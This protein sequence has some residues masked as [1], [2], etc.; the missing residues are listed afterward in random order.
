MIMNKSILDN[1]KKIKNAIFIFLLCLMPFLQL[2][3]GMYF[4]VQILALV[5]LLRQYKCVDFK[6]SI[7][8][9]CYSFF[10]IAINNIFY[11][12]YNF[13]LSR[14]LRMAFIASLTIY[15]VCSPKTRLV[16]ETFNYRYVL[17]LLVALLIIATIQFLLL[18]LGQNPYIPSDWFSIP[19]DRALGANW[20]SFAVENELEFEGRI[21]GFYSEP[22]YLG[23]VSI[24]L[25]LILLANGS[26]VQRVL[27]TI[28]A[29]LISIISQSGLGIMGNIFITVLAYRRLSTAMVYVI[30][31]ILIS[32]VVSTALLDLLPT[33][34]TA[35]IS[36]T[37]GSTVGRMFKPISLIIE[38]FDHH[39][40]G[41]SLTG[42]NGFFIK[43]N[44]VADIGE[45]PT[46]NGFYN[47][48]YN[49][50]FVAFGYFY[51]LFKGRNWYFIVG[52]LLIMFQSGSAFSFDKLV[53]Y[54][55]LSQFTIFKNEPKDT[56]E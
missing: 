10:L 45:P 4:S 55:L 56:H 1:G 49:Y 12:E 29:L 18:K 13:I 9:F 46:D 35:I 8:F 52:I 6:P 11:P 23:C 22:S 3:I 53:M 37:D 34:I 50:G 44:L 42:I 40:F 41:V 20:F 19:G 26:P 32:L 43:Y 47:T 25:H 51:V 28:L 54:V 24:L 16:S 33:R 7:I 48:F 39:P 15:M 38:I 31:A 27:S 36:G 17:Y 14:D 2:G 5:V 30:P 21:T